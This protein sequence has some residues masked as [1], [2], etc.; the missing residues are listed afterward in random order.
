MKRLIFSQNGTV[1]GQHKKDI[2]NG[3]GE[4]GIDR[5]LTSKALE[6]KPSNAVGIESQMG[7]QSFILKHEKT[8]IYM[9]E[10]VL[11]PTR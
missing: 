9:I 3:L 4:E 10:L 8:N 1:S 11:Y 2:C 6:S 7:S 5:I